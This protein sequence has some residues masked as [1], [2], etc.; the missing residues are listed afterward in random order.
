[1]R[2]YVS[3]RY[4]KLML[5]LSLRC[6][7]VNSHRVQDAHS[8]DKCLIVSRLFPTT[9]C[10]G[11]E[12]RIEKSLEFACEFQELERFESFDASIEND[13][14]IVDVRNQMLTSPGIKTNC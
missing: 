6:E 1:M 13:L 9:S 2:S 14:L 10:Q 5:T 3:L 11:V 12:L 4:E 8:Y 7:N